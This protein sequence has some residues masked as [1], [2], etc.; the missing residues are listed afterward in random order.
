MGDQIDIGSAD[1]ACGLEGEMNDQNIYVDGNNDDFGGQD[2]GACDQY[3]CESDQND[4]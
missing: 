3:V 2:D 1:S 4:K